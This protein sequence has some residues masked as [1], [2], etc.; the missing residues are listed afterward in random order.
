[1]H[2]LLELRAKK[3]LTAFFSDWKR[4][5]ESPMTSHSIQVDWQGRAPITGGL[6]AYLCL[7]I[8]IL[9]HDGGSSS[10]IITPARIS[11]IHW[12]ATRQQPYDR[13]EGIPGRGKLGPRGCVLPMSRT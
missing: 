3:S 9:A 6:Y 13:A 1:M 12:A 8:S 10:I 7:C 11:Y 5:P 2:F 4:K